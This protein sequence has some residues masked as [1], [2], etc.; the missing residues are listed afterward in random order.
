MP[1]KGEIKEWF[2]WIQYGLENDQEFSI[3]FRDFNEYIE[4]S[5]VEFMERRRIDN[6]PLHRISQIRKR[7]IP[8]FTRPNFCSTCG[9]PLRVDKCQN[10]QCPRSK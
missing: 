9:N 8:V 5:F 3:I 6:I 4:L 10:K 7:G 1:K 2:S